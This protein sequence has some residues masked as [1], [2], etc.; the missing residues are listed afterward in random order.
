MWSVSALLGHKGA[1]ESPLTEHVETIVQT[2]WSEF[3]ALRLM[4]A[5][6]ASQ[7]LPKVLH[8]FASK[9]CCICL[10]DNLAID[11]VSPC[12]G[13]SLHLE[14][15]LRWLS[16]AGSN[17]PQCRKEI[18]WKPASV[19]APLVAA[20]GVPAALSDTTTT[21][22]SS[23]S[24]DTTTTTVAVPTAAVESDTTTTTTVVAP[25]DVCV[26]C[27]ISRPLSDYSRN[28]IV[29]KTPGNRKCKICLN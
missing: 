20:A 6:D 7:A 19:P 12:C 8:D 26:L 1:C 13:V 11:H 15:L 4:R 27:G 5:N 16:S 14:C 10:C 21:A 29:N 9:T 24:S 18:D 22:A 28:Q 2:S 3:K 25:G 23:E 17:C